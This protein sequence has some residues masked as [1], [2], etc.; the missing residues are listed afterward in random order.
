MVNIDEYRG[1]PCEERSC[2][3]KMIVHF[4]LL[5]SILGHFLLRPNMDISDQ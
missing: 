1:M 4:V 2:I 5:L 3:R